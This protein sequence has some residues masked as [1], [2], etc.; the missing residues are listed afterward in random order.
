[1]RNRNNRVARAQWW[2]YQR[3]EPKQR[4]LIRHSLNSNTHATCF[5]H[6]EIVIRPSYRISR[7]KDHRKFIAPTSPTH[8]SVNGCTDLRIRLLA[9]NSRSTANALQQ[10]CA[11]SLKHLC[12]PIDDLASQVRRA[13]AP[14]GKGSACSLD[15][16]A[17][18]FATGV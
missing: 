11:A 1:M 13:A 6:A 8:C 12:K 16:L 14:S 18:I 10:L 7:A 15:C 5:W 9:R 2:Q 17:E 3:E 4:V